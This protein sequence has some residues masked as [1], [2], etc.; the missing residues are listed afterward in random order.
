MTRATRLVLALNGSPAEGGSVARLLDAVGEGAREG[1]AEFVLLRCADLRVRD[2][3][4]CGPDATTGWCI[5]HDDMDRVY[6]AIVRAHAIVVGAPVWFD[7]L[8]SPLKRVVDRCNCMTPLV[9]LPGG[10]MGTVPKLA[11]TRRGLFVVAGSAEHPYE[12]AERS[13]RGWMK[14]VGAKWEETIAWRHTDYGHGSVDEGL[15]ERARASGR[16]LA[17]APPLEP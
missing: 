8:P 3:I 5:F 15:L 11:R 14:W 4:A 6:D 2:C 17:E 7:G 9:T 16:R 10:G 13:V 1:G 12:A